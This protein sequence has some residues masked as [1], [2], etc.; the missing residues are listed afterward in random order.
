MDIYNEVINYLDNKNIFVEKEKIDEGI[1]QIAF[2]LNKQVNIFFYDNS[3]FKIFVYDK[4]EISDDKLEKTLEFI[5]EAN[6]YNKDFT[7]SIIENKVY[8][9]K[10]VPVIFDIKACNIFS[11]IEMLESKYDYIVGKLCDL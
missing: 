11:F 1:F 4:F 10:A 7:V 2:K 3:N 5:N 6:L 8:L 9:M